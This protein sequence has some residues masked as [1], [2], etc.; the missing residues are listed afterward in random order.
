MGKS[1]WQLDI[2]RAG[3]YREEYEYMVR[4]IAST[5]QACRVPFAEAW[6]H[7]VREAGRILDGWLARDMVQE[8]ASLPQEVLE[9]LL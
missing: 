3:R 5:E 1:Q 9:K 8:I 2:E 4:D 6:D 7:A